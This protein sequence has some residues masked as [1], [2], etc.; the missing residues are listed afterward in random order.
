MLTIYDFLTACE[1]C[2]I[3]TIKIR[4]AVYIAERTN[5][6][7]MQFKLSYD[8][9]SKAMGISYSTTAKIMKQLQDADMIEPVAR[10]VWKWVRPIFEPVK[11]QDLA[12]DKLEI[13]FKNYNA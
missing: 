6:S 2:G 12:S 8:E 3:D 11:D 4:T 1:V 9:I 10:G 13:C 5:P 7:T